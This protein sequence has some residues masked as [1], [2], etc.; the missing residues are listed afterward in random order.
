[1]EPLGQHIFLRFR[2]DRIIAP[3]V[4]EQRIVARVVLKA[5]RDFGLL[6][7]SAADTHLHMEN[8]GSR[9]EG[10][11]FARRVEIA[12][13][14][15]LTPKARFRHPGMEEIRDQKHLYNTFTYVLKQDRRHGLCLDP[16]RD[17]SNL[18]DLLGLRILGRYTSTNVRR[19]L[20]R[21]RRSRLL[22]CLGVSELNPVDGPLDQLVPAAAAAVGRTEL[23]GRA[24]E[25]IGARRAVVEIIGAQLG[26]TGT[27]RLLGI[28]RRSVYRL[29]TRPAD[30]EL[31][32]A[33]R[34]QLAL[35]GKI[36]LER[37]AFAEPLPETDS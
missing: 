2:N 27:A 17:A 15:S 16:L 28:H 12:L 18:P 11:E 30:P 14:R 37:G 24:A 34:L 26:C 29:R 35:L 36:T 4:R 21:M 20:P 19:Y 13:W 10:I 23:N 32:S 6:A 33:V 7:F 3:S 8:V 22:E 1:M 9:P 25:V 31:V 5:G